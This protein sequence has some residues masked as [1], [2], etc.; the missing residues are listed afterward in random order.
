G[1]VS[2]NIFYQ[3]RSIQL[4]PLLR[5]H[6]GPVVEAVALSSHVGRRKPDPSIYQSVLG[7][8]GLEPEDVIFV[9]D[10]L[11]EDVRGPLALGMAAAYLTHEFRQEPDAAG[12]AEATLQRV[13][14]LTGYL[15]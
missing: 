10:R 13:G 5:G 8:M 4:F 14:D 1:I 3:E 7:Q 2:N 11:R 12:E 6:V 15:A 9:G